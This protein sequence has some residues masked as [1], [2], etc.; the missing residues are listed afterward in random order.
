MTPKFRAWD[1]GTG[2]M[3]DITVIDLENEEIYYHHWRYGHSTAT[4]TAIAFSDIELMQSTGLKDKSGVEIFE[5]DVVKV[6]NMKGLVK[7]G[8]Y[9]DDE[10]IIYGLDGWLFSEIYHGRYIDIPLTEYVLDS[11]F[12]VEVIGNKYEHPELL[13]E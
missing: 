2:L 5:G 7:F 6:N 10:Y 8:R 11:D 9:T 13:G 4:A 1:K 3:N 12:E